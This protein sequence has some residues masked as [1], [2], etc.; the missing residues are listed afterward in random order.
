MKRIEDE[1]KSFNEQVTD[2]TNAINN[3]NT[4]LDTHIKDNLG[5]VWFVSGGGTINAMS[6]TSDKIIL[7]DANPPKPKLG[8]AYRFFSNY[9]HTGNVTLKVSDGV[10]TSNAIPILRSNGTQIPSGTMIAGGIYTVAFNGTN[11]ILQG[12]SGVTSPT[13][14]SQIFGTPGTY[15]FIVPTGVTRI[16]YKIWGA[17]GGGGGSSRSRPYIGGGGGGGG[18]YA[19]GFINVSPGSTISLR[20]GTGGIGGAPNTTTGDLFFIAGSGT[21]SSI[22]GGPT[23]YGGRGGTCAYWDSDN[24]DYNGRG[25]RGGQRDGLGSPNGPTNASPPKQG[26]PLSMGGYAEKDKILAF[27]GGTDG[28]YTTSYSGGAGAGGNSDAF[29]GFVTIGPN[30]NPQTICNTHAGGSGG[31]GG[32]ANG[33]T[34][35]NGDFASGGGGASA[36]SP[37]A[38]T[39]DKVGGNGGDG[40]IILYW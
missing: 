24:P 25:G 38:Y 31:S 16:M 34:G 36:Y 29:G 7:D 22:E 3:V 6:V 32:N 40:R 28:S 2:N 5:H 8:S 33:T 19:S 4:K 14:G 21:S 27:I 9:T 1:S 11:F 12:E 17:G 26:L 37:A 30:S 20:V 39:G 15:S 10:K 18:A 13:N 23:V 35:Y